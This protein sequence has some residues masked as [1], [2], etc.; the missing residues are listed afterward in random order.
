MLVNDHNFISHLIHNL[1]YQDNNNRNVVIN[2]P[3][4]LHSLCTLTCYK[5]NIHFRQENDQQAYQ[6]RDRSRRCLH[7]IQIRGDASD[8][9]ELVNANYARVLVIAIST[10]SGSG[11]EDDFEIRIRLSN[12]SE[13][14][15]CLHIGRYNDELYFPPQ[16]LL[17][18]RSDEQIEEEGGNE[19]IEAQLINNREI[20]Y[21]G[22]IKS[23]ANGAKGWILN[24]FIKWG[25][26]RP[27]CKK[28]NPSYGGAGEPV[29]NLRSY[30]RF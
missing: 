26:P 15:K 21:I 7:D 23:Q 25:N 13:F 30:L 18:H 22:N 24:Y 29:A 17:A 4:A 14:I 27:E 2:T 12:I 19:E 16:P 8:Q 3:N 1:I 11:E 5:I 6:I 9:S 10:A 28:A 20:Q